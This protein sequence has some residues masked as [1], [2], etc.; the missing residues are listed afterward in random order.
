M[1][2]LH[3]SILRII[4]SAVSKNDPPPPPLRADRVKN[5]LIVNT[6]AI[7]DTLL[8]TPAIRNI[9]KNFPKAVITALASK[10]A[11]PVLQG[12]PRVDGIIEYPGRINL[13][14]ML[15]LPAL[16]RKLRKGRFD[17]AVVLHANDPDTGP[18]VYITGAPWR[19]KINWEETKFPFLYSFPVKAAPPE[20]HEV[21]I[22]LRNLGSYGIKAGG[23][24]LELFL[25]DADHKEAAVFADKLKKNKKG[26]IV[27][28]PFGSKRNKWWDSA[29]VERFCGLVAEKF[30]FTPV[31]IG[32]AGEA[33]FAEGMAKASGAVSAAGKLSIRGSAALIYNSELIVTTD[34]GPMHMAQAL[35]VP[36]V[37]LFGP[38]DHE[39][40]GP[41]NKNDIV[42]RKEL[43]CAP[44][45]EKT[46]RYPQNDC[47]R[48]ITPEEVLD[49]VQKRLSKRMR[50]FI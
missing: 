10:S 25:T 50:S 32:G 3:H 41:V 43:P 21:D 46:C 30:G 8:S 15:K 11:E 4:F 33:P 24:D 38:D 16:V 22:K 27:V 26:F 1:S 23:R 34:S 40:T 20:G 14:Y 29:N 2:K 37:A 18:L 19:M 6:T 47:M 39:A 13:R 49:S 42:I 36:T 5:I 7:G 31:L 48:S 9:R 45:R 12:N 28:H 17:L 44:C 35:H